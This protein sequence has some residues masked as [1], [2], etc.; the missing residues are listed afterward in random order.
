[1]ARASLKGCRGSIIGGTYSGGGAAL[2]L[3]PSDGCSV[4]AGALSALL[5]DSST[6]KRMTAHKAAPMPMARPDSPD[7]GRRTIGNTDW[8]SGG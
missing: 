4:T 8:L 2:A 5:R 7:R 3:M 6:T 1:M